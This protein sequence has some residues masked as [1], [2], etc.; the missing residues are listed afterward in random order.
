MAGT[1]FDPR[2]GFAPGPSGFLL[3]D[4]DQN[5]VPGSGPGEKDNFSVGQGP[6]PKTP[7]T[8]TMDGNLH[9]RRHAERSSY[10]RPEKGHP[11][12]FHAENPEAPPPETG[13]I[14]RRL[15]SFS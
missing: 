2:Q 13:V 10:R 6:D 7:G 8:D 1:L 9:R 5:S 11:A 14:R 4:S 12:L 15:S 3:D